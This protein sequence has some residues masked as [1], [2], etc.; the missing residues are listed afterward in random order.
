MVR[1]RFQSLRET[2]LA[3]GRRVECFGDGR[4][5]FNL[6]PRVCSLKANSR[7]PD[8]RNDVGSESAQPKLTEEISNAR[9]VAAVSSDLAIGEM[10]SS[11]CPVCVR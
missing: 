6:V 10:I 9:L 11:W 8:R 4:N 1:E 7:G 3:G 5:D 2:H